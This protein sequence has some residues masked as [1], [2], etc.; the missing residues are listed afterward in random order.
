MHTNKINGKKYVGISKNPEKRW[1]NYQGCTHF[2]NAI[3]KYG[4]DNFEHEIL[5]TGLTEKQAIAKETE[6]IIRYDT[7]ENGYN[8]TYGGSACVS[9]S[10]KMRDAQAERMS[11]PDYN[12]MTNGTVIFGVTHK[13]PRAKGVEVTFPEGSVL[14]FNSV[15]DCA[16]YFGVVHSRIL[17]I[18]S[19]PQPFQLSK[20]TKKKA[21]Y[22]NERVLF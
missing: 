5:L 10:K 15:R 13:K 17:K 21:P 11:N 19:N 22:Q 8:L 7:V 18:L 2:Y 3:Q 20:Y 14:E 9:W 1:K 12:P 4:F 16:K 6:Y